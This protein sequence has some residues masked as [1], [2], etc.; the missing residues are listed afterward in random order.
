MASIT[1]K[2][3]GKCFDFDRLSESHLGGIVLKC[4]QKEAVANLME[5]K[6]VLAVLPTGFGKSFCFSE[7]N[8]GKLC[9]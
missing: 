1:V 3:S 8:G 5:G 9:W 4:E 6:D 7:G 2:F